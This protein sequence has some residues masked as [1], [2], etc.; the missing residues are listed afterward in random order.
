MV[1]AAI[2]L[3]LVMLLVFGIIEWGLA[4]L[5]ATSTNSAARSGARTASALTKN[6]SYADQAV[7]AV[8][9]NMKGALPFATP[10][11]LWIYRVD[12]AVGNTTGYPVGQPGFSGCSTDC[13]K[14]TWD[15]TQW[16]GPATPVWAASTQQAC[17]S[18]TAFDSVGVTT[19]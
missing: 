1:E 2:V 8:T 7:L 19:S 6:S 9:Q 12:P 14:Y 10:L 3:P 11:E 4:F 18:P 15:G 16:V 13:T 5:T 17:G